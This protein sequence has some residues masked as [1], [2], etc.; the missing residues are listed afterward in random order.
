MNYMK[1]IYTLEQK[2][3]LYETKSFGWFIGFLFSQ[4]F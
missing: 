3:P 4:L 2:E 1:G